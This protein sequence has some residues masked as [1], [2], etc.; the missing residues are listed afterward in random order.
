MNYESLRLSTRGI[1]FLLL[2]LFLPVFL[3]WAGEPD[4][5]K[6]P[7]LLRS[8]VLKH[9]VYV[10]P[11]PPDKKPENENA[12]IFKT[13]GW[14]ILLLEEGITIEPGEWARAV[15]L[16]RSEIYKSEIFRPMNSDF[17]ISAYSEKSSGRDKFRGADLLLLARFGVATEG[18]RIFVYLVERATGNTV[19]NSDALGSTMK[20]AISKVLTELENE[21]S[22]HAWRCRIID[23]TNTEM[24]IDRGSLDGLEKGQKFA[25]YEISRKNR[26]N[27]SVSSEYLIMRYGSKKGIYVVKEA[28][29]EY[30]KVVPAGDAPLLKSGDVLALPG[31][32][33]KKRQMNTRARKVWDRIYKK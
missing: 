12:F 26:E 16:L 10:V 28:G 23:T 20:E 14:K 27:S 21:M 25:G 6:D 19:Y 29:Q 33:F 9:R 4:G 24:I 30:S 8:N 1:L 22:L 17:D 2:L 31:I 7:L 15:D 13:E 11:V 5:E 18:Y 3:V 32:S